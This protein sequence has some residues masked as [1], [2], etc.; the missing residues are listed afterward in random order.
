MGHSALLLVDAVINLALG[1]LLLAFPRSLVVL[2]GLPDA[3]TAFYPNVLGGVLFGI[4]LALLLERWKPGGWATGLGLTGA[5][6]INLCGGTVLAL[7]VM[8]GDLE[9]APRGRVI[10]GLLAVLLFTVSGFEL[11]MQVASSRSEGSA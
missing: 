7:W 9:L 5:I 1:V 11:R 4:G 10:L 3:R 2:L 8:L 6:A